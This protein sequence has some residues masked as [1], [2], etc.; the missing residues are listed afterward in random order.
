VK[1]RQHFDG[2][3][4]TRG[5]ATFDAVRALVDALP[6]CVFV[7]G[8]SG[9]VLHANAAARAQ[10]TASQGV[11]ALFGAGLIASLATA[12]APITTQVA[13]KGSI[14]RFEFTP[15]AWE[16]QPAWLV[17]ESDRSFHLDVF[18]NGPDAIFIADASGFYRDV[19]PAGL[20]LLR[21]SRD[22][23]IGHHITEFIA[24]SDLSTRPTAYAHIEESKPFVVD[25]TMK[26]GDG[27]SFPASVLASRLPGGWLQGVLRDRTDAVKREEIFR[28]AEKLD[29]IG[30]LSGGIA[31]D[32][33]NLLTV[34]GSLAS[35][36]E[37]EVPTASGR[38]LLDE[39]QSVVTRG[40]G[41]T[42]QLLSFAKTRQAEPRP[43]DVERSI[44]NFSQLLSRV[45]TE[46][47]KLELDLAKTSSS[48]WVDPVQFEQVLLNL[49]VNARDAMPQGGTLSISTAR[50]FDQVRIRV[51]D[52]GV[53]MSR[54]TQ[55]RLFEPF[56]TTKLGRGTGLGLATAHGI[57][58]QANGRIEVSSEPGAGT[59]FTLLFTCC[60]PAA[61]DSPPVFALSNATRRHEVVL[62]VEDD[63]QVRGGVRRALCNLGYEVHATADANEALALCRSCTRI[64]LLLTDVVLREFGGVRLASEMRAMRPTLPVL[65]VS[66]HAEVATQ[67]LGPMLPKPFTT[68]E[69]EAALAGVLVPERSVPAG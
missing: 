69:L 61:T 46:N 68:T 22:Q 1:G 32:F 58:T 56:F 13:M 16:G 44:S 63:P 3:Q 45:L 41:L 50:E 37:A 36:L 39:L 42:R 26:R 4:F 31:H 10:L 48:V 23:I 11:G 35:V 43:T 34:V 14:R 12:D 59:T 30:R 28:Q 24:A 7:L 33:N 66:G 20:R 51:R 40:A 15:H 62:L 55:A 57:V 60:E 21:C 17:C 67:G 6:Q 64:D 9:E 49:A 8:T 5:S 54:D 25:R 52:T 29:T 65:F 27:T 2:V 47:I 19:N 18:E 38:A 53:G